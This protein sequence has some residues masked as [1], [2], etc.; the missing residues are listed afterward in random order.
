MAEITERLGHAMTLFLLAAALGMD[1]FSLCVGIGMRGIRLL[2]AAKISAAI[3]ACHV[4]MPLAGMFMGKY[5]SA[6]LGGVAVMF[7]G[8]LLILLGGHMIYSSF[9]G[10]DKPS[11]DT[12]SWMGLIAFAVSVSVD[13]LSV[14]V[15]LGVFAAEL[16]PAVLLFGFMGGL[17]SVAG[18]LVGRRV[19]L[20]V[21]DSGEAIGGAILLAFGILFF[22]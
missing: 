5:V 17:M 11:F 14:G 20:L 4:V 13:S 18:L 3:A 12:G 15:S 22:F 8:A 2:H 10:G 9:R 21:G 1:A 6:L 19:G 16:V 7:G